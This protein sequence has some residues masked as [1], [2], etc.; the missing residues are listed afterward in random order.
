MI[1][2]GR[3]LCVAGQI[4]WDAQ[5]VF[6]TDDLIGQFD[7]A[8][9]NVVAVVTAAGAAITDLASM[10]IYV[11]DIEGYRAR[12]KELGPVWRARLGKHFPAMALVAVAALVEPR[13]K[14]EIQATAFVP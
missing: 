13:A 9:A 3:T 12:L 1:G 14:V 5:G 6:H 2:A 7:Q 8:L 11:T 4:G 10:T